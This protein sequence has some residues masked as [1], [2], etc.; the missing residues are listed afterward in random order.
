ME[1]FCI[2]NSSFCCV[3]CMRMVFRMDLR[4]GSFLMAVSICVLLSTLNALIRK[5]LS[6]F[7]LCVWTLL[8]R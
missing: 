5:K 8:R 7:F 2:D 6:K 4:K 3:L 1:W